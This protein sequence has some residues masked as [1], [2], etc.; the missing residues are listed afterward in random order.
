MQASIC[1]NYHSEGPLARKSAKSARRVVDYARVRGISAQLVAVLDR[2]DDITMNYVTDA[3]VDWDEILVTDFGDLGKARNFATQSLSSD[4]L[5][6]LDGDDLCGETWLFDA[7]TFWESNNL[8]TGILHPEFVYYFDERDYDV[9]PASGR[10]ASFW[11]RH[12]SSTAETFDEAALFWNN[13]YTSNNLA[14]RELLL[15]Y[16]LIARC[17]QHQIGVEDWQWNQ[18]TLAAGI[19]HLAVPGTVHLVRV[20]AAES[21]SGANSR[22]GLLPD[23]G[24]HWKSAHALSPNAT[25]SP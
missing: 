13:V 5:S 16:P 2:P 17:V 20:T 19:S 12:L 8:E 18:K 4:F 24:D 21:L 6:F 7:L 15:E 1:V 25:E 11:F 22:L 14:P 10:K 23:F 3:G 9:D